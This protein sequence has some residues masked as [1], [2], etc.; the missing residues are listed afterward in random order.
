MTVEIERVP[1]VDE[2]C[3]ALAVHFLRTEPDWLNDPTV[4]TLAV[5][6]QEA[7]EDWFFDRKHS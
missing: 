1:R 3:I 6:I 4:E 5:V 7:V 2:K